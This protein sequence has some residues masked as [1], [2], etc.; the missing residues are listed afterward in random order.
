MNQLNFDPAMGCPLCGGEMKYDRSKREYQCLYCRRAFPVAQQRVQKEEEGEGK[1][2]GEDPLSLLDP[3]FFEVEF[4]WDDLNEDSQKSVE[5]FCDYMQQF[6]TSGEIMEK[7]QKEYSWD[8]DLAMPGL[9]EEILNKVRGN[10][11]PQLEPGEKILL[12]IDDDVFFKG[13][14]GF[15]ITNKRTFTSAKK[16]K[17]NVWHKQIS[18]IEK[19]ELNWRLNKSIDAA[20]TTIGADEDLQGACAALVCTLVFEEDPEHDPI[21]LVSDDF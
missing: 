9:H 17:T 20:I 14:T 11:D 16:W 7:I 12:F 3:A 6:R 10:V 1:R 15:I 8:E 2:S 21:R 19:S 5:K 13:R 4:K 18:I